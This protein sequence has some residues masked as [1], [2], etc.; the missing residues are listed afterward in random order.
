MAALI[1]ALD[2][3]TPKQF[4]QKGAIEYGWSNDIRESVLQFSGQIVRS[5]ENRIEQMADKLRTLLRRLSLK[6]TIISDAERKELLVVLYKVIALTRDIVDGKGEYAL[7]YMQVFVWYEFY[8]SLA[9][10][11][12]EKFVL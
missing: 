6:E 12:L 8:P 9:T 4:G 5:D 10:F 3:S 1:N 7:A 2:T 11:A